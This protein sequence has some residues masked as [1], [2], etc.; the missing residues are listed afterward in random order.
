MGIALLLIIFKTV[1]N[2]IPKVWEVMSKG[3]ASVEFEKTAAS[4]ARKMANL[5]FGCLLVTEGRSVVGVVTERDLVRKILAK[6]V[7]ANK[8]RVGEVMSQPLI[9]VEPSTELGDATRL[10]SEKLIKRLVVMEHGAPLGILTMT[11]IANY[12]ANTHLYAVS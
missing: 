12:L 8:I 5:G 6:N 3:I 9:T 4:A 10:M 2:A 1:V 7:D 11:D